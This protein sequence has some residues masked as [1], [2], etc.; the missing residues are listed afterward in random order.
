MDNKLQHLASHM[1]DQHGMSA[2]FLELLMLGT[3][4]A[5]LEH[6]LIQDLGEKGL[7][8]LGHS[9]DVS[10][11]NMQ[12]L[13]LKYLHTVSQ[14]LNFHLAEMKGHIQA[15]DKYEA[16]LKI[17]V[18]SVIEA[19]QNAAVLWAKAV[20]L[21]Q[22][23]DESKK[24]FK[25]FFKWL[26][27]EILRLSEEN[28]SEELSKT[29]QQDIQ[30]IADFLASFSSV[31]S[32]D[33][34]SYLEK[35]GQ[36]LKNDELSQPIDRSKNPWY[37]F[38]KENPDVAN[39]PEIIQVDEKASLVQAY[40][41]LEDSIKAVFSTLDSD[42][43]QVCVPQ[44][45]L[46]VNSNDIP[47]HQSVVGQM[48]FD[49]GKEDRINAFMMTKTINSAFSFLFLSWNPVLSTLN[50]LRITG[51]TYLSCSYS[52]VTQSFYTHDVVSVLLASESTPRRLIQLPISQMEPYMAN[53]TTSTI[54][55]QD[56]HILPQQS[57]FSLASAVS[58]GLNET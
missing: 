5:A 23:I 28:I 51:G 43:S 21:Q 32:P 35:V 54:N 19:Q 3:P 53:L 33:S 27:V 14:A 4:S 46:T 1:P 18:E 7:K 11:S 45:K 12:R 13:V 20:E 34:Y 41:R 36:Y 55:L 38:L 56:A 31:S 15:S 29:S 6:F 57:I 22:V 44:R 48:E 16:V 49:Y 37:Q 10:Y 2:D 52:I 24:C 30:F 50:G 9:I 47:N 26:Y 25:A 39:I 17:S 42:F 40:Q 8:K 58:V